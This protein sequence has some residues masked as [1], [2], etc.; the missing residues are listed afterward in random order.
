MNSTLTTLNIHSGE[1][2]CVSLLTLFLV[3]LTP[4]NCTPVDPSYTCKTRLA[5]AFDSNFR[6]E[7]EVQI[8]FLGSVAFALTMDTRVIQAIEEFH[9]SHNW[10]PGPL[11]VPCCRSLEDSTLQEVDLVQIIGPK[12]RHA[13]LSDPSEV[14]SVIGIMSTLHM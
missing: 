7:M 9:Q 10:H 12:K 1:E 14:S 4:V 8:I 11:Y 6:S 3:N 5:R 13:N 2:V